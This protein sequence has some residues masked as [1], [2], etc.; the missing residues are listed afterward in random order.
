V[1]ES[2]EELRQG[3]VERYDTFATALQLVGLVGIWGEKPLLDGVAMKKALP[4]IPEGPAFRKVME[5]QESWITSHP[6]GGVDFLTKHLSETFP[7][8]A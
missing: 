6:G 8:Y 2:Q 3:I 7:E 1:D 5:E 4:R